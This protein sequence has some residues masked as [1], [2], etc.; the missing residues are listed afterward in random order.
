MCSSICVWECAIN[1]PCSSIK[2]RYPGVIDRLL[3][4]ESSGKFA[5]E[6]IEGSRTSTRLNTFDRQ[7]VV[8]AC[9]CPTDDADYPMVH[10][11][12]AGTDR[13]VLVEVDNLRTESIL[14]FAT[15]HGT[16]YGQ[17][18]RI[19]TEGGNACVGQ[20]ADCIRH[21]V[22][23]LCCTRKRDQHKRVPFGAFNGLFVEVRV[24]CV[25]ELRTVAHT[26]RMHD[27]RGQ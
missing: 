10:E 19:V 3:V 23:R 12:I 17:M 11:F 2:V 26:Q 14:K 8:E 21:I 5:I 25:C 16:G 18:T 4:G 7:R 22:V 20:N 15:C 13:S 27:E 24:V 9:V 1:Q 6:M